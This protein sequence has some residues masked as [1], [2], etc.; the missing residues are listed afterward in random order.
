MKINPSVAADVLKTF[1]QEDRTEARIYR[2]RVENVSYS[3]TVA[4][5]AISAFLIGNLSHMSAHQLRYITL[6]ID[7]GLVAVMLI[8]FLRIHPDI[9]ALRKAMRT[10]QGL[11]N[12]LNE[13]EMQDINPFPD[14]SEEPYPDI[15]DSDLYLVVGLSAA[16]VLV[17]MLV[18]ATSA[19]SFVVAKGNP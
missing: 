2:G 16:V 14:V 5:F 19:A 4:S 1:V 8:F 10:R 11:L 3:L 17:K 15:T 9:V 13:G 18:L 7:L 12:S 6:L